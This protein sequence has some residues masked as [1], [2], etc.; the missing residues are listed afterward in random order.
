MI[1][2]L[3][4]WATV[5]RQS[6]SIAE[7]YINFIAHAA[8]PQAMTLAEIQE[9]TQQ[10]D[11]LLLL[12]AAI[13]T[14]IWTSDRLKPY[15]QIKNEI[16]VDY[17]NKIL[18]RGTRIILPDALREHAIKIAHEGHQGQSKTIAL[19]R[20]YV[21]FPNMG[22]FVKNFI[23]QCIVCQASAKPNAPEPLQ[24]TAM[25]NRPW[26]EVKVDFCSPFPSGHYVLVVIDCYSR[27][28]EVEILKSTSAPKVIP[29]LD[30][31]FP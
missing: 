20:E 21:W 18:L 28:P 5:E 2:V 13:K 17:T 7:E 4:L 30:T 19:L 9:A 26:E 12:Q 16:T 31:I 22:K 1:F 25:P 24:S 11:T 3:P 27:F 29:K 23:D 15:K 6:K 8:V 10:D 14:G